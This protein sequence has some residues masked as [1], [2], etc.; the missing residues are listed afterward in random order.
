MDG[1]Y[2]YMC[3]CGGGLFI[4]LSIYLFIDVH[5]VDMI[6][7][8]YYELLWMDYPVVHRWTIWIIMDYMDY[9]GMDGFFGGLIIERLIYWRIL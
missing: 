8:T 9:Y 7:P 3:V 6:I 4:Y 2:T 1:F 5:R